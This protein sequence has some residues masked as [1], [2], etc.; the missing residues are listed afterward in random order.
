MAGGWH[1]QAQ[2]RGVGRRRIGSCW[3][4]EGSVD[5]NVVSSEFE[6]C[7]DVLDDALSICIAERLYMVWSFP[8][9][10]RVGVNHHAARSGK[11]FRVDA[12]RFSCLRVE[13]ASSAEN[14]YSKAVCAL[15]NVGVWDAK[16]KAM[17]PEP[18]RGELL[19]CR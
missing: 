12:K 6:C 18:G 14:F 13:K 3:T 2:P 10:Y 4:G 5:L 7:P 11:H 19:R 9:V 8:V 1:L 17:E 16:H 15:D